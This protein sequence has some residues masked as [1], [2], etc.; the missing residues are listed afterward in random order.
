M[1]EVLAN[2]IWAHPALSP[3]DFIVLVIITLVVECGIVG[4][5]LNFLDVTDEKI[6]AGVELAVIFSNIV[7]AIIGWQIL[8]GLF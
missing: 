1:N 6:Y 7:T 3:L 5:V 2:P 4:A 8:G